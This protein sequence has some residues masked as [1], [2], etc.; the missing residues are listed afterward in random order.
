L[1]VVLFLGYSGSGK[2]TAIEYVARALN[3]SGQK[4]GTIKHIHERNFTIDRERKDTWRHAVSGASIIVAIAP[5]ELAVIRKQNTAGI[6]IDEILHVFEKDHVDCVLVEGLYR[7]FSTVPRAG[8]KARQRIFDQSRYLKDIYRVLCATNGKDALDLL[9][10]YSPEL[11]TC[12]SGKIT[13][14]K[15]LDRKKSFHGIPLV[16]L[17]LDVGKLLQLIGI[18]SGRKFRA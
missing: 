14:S 7:K 16:R 5:K 3:K 1:K 8:S 2:T 18:P 10:K 12:I 4:V 9:R 15:D 17:P 6:T 13:E 11:I